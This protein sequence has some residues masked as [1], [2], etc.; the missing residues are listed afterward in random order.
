VGR[1]RPRSRTGLGS[2][3]CAAVSSSVAPTRPV[4]DE[5]H[6]REVGLV[7]HRGAFFHVT[8]R[9]VMSGRNVLGSRV[10]LNDETPTSLLVLVERATEK[11]VEG[12][13]ECVRRKH[14]HNS[15]D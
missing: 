2:R 11:R 1:R 6:D 7:R 15:E 12:G 10:T 13:V 4:F 14:D 8:S 9:A 5:L 3:R